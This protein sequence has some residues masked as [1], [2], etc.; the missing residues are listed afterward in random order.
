MYAFGTDSPDDDTSV[1]G[2]R[3]IRGSLLQFSPQKSRRIQQM[4]QPLDDRTKES[5]WGCN[6]CF[7]S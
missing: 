7:M 3:L 5:H 6:H 1:Q 4:M 2:L